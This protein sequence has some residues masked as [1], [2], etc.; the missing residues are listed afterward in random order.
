MKLAADFAQVCND[1]I[2]GLSKIY[3]CADADYMLS[4]PQIEL[5]ISSFYDRLTELDCCYRVLHFQDVK[6][7]AQSPTVGDV[8]P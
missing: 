7:F 1:N 4:L 6:K 5:A 2:L 3:F 8:I